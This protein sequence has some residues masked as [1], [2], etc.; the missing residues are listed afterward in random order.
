VGDETKEAAFG[1]RA[2]IAASHAYARRNSASPL[3]VQNRGWRI[4]PALPERVKCLA[5][6]N[7]SSGS[8]QRNSLMT[9]RKRIRWLVLLPALLVVGLATLFAGFSSPLWHIEHL[10]RPQAVRSTTDGELVLADG[11]SIALPYIRTLPSRK[12]SISSGPVAGRR[13]RSARR[14][15]WTAVV[16]PQL[17]TRS[18]A[19]AKTT[20]ESERLGRGVASGW[21]R[22][23][24]CPSRDCGTL[25]KCTRGSIY[26]RPVAVIGISI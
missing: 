21:N 25:A 9:W 12:P 7:G 2:M 13:S 1:S 23:L 19:V 18:G 15:T 5:G 14:N 10:D 26:R 6:S 24:A 3:P 4:V 22:R 16:R 11:R 8:R 20:S 17:R